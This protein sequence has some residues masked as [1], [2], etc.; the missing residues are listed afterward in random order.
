MISLVVFPMPEKTILLGLIPAF[1][2]L[3]NSPIETTS[4]PNPRLP[5]SFNK[6]LFGFDFTEKQIRG[7]I[8]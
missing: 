7:F 6:I 8:L 1:K 4:A 3:I 2:A 5:I